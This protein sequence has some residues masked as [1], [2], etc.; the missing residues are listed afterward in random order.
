M[1][2]LRH[3]EIS[4]LIPYQPDKSPVD[5][6]TMSRKKIQK[7][8]VDE[9]TAD[10]VNSDNQPDIFKLN[11]ICLIHIFSFLS[12]PE[13]IRIQR[14]C[15]RW[16]EVSA[17]VWCDIKKLEIGE[18]YFGFFNNSLKCEKIDLRIVKQ[19]LRMCGPCLTHIQLNSVED[20]KHYVATNKKLL[21]LVKELCPNLK[22][23]DF[24]FSICRRSMKFIADNFTNLRQCSIV[25]VRNKLDDLLSIFLLRSK[26]LESINLNSF[27]TK[28]SCM[29]DLSTETIKHITLSDCNL[30][31]PEN[32]NHVCC[33]ISVTYRKL[34]WRTYMNVHALETLS[35]IYSRK[36]IANLD[37]ILRL[38]PEQSNLKTLK[39]QSRHRLYGNGKTINLSYVHKFTNLH[40]LELQGGDV[41]H[42]ET[43][44]NVG[45]H[46]KNLQR[47][48]LTCSRRVKD[49]GLQHIARLPKLDYL[50]LEDIPWVTKKSVP[51]LLELKSF[52]CRRCE[53]LEERSY[54]LLIEMSRNLEYIEVGSWSYSRVLFIKYDIEKKRVS[55]HPLKLCVDDRTIQF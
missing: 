33:Y 18:K 9:G 7:V 41:L 11:D 29:L 40:T 13:R 37:T 46:C 23:I 16:Q 48:I 24:S 17:L 44:V 35:I 3:K 28:G 42:D 52:K 8:E 49:S 19:V 12:I 10:T 51:H 31:L 15:K 34:I 5:G 38:A 6:E 32:L 14:V 22:S 47:A 1:S 50:E 25:H 53:R 26:N 2:G 4:P 39:I 30:F 36:L 45:Q 27:N 21:I 20:S 54:R 55:S 43:L